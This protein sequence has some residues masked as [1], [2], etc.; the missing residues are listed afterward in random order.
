[1]NFVA[2]I[3][4]N[5]EP[6]AL[7]ID[8]T[9]TCYEN[10]SDQTSS[11]FRDVV[12]L[13]STFKTILQSLPQNG[14]DITIT[15]PSF[16]T[17]EMTREVKQA[18]KAAGFRKCHW[19]DNI[20][21]VQQGL[22]GID[23]TAR[24]ELL[25]E[26]GG[27]TVYSRLVSTDIESGIRCS[28]IIQ[29]KAAEHTGS[30]EPMI[31]QSIDDAMERL[32]VEPT[33]SAIHRILIIS[34][35][36]KFNPSFITDLKERELSAEIIIE[37]DVSQWAAKHSLS[38][39]RSILEAICIFN[40]SPLNVSI[41]KADGFVHTLIG[42]NMTLPN[43]QTAIF[44]TEKKDQRQVTVDVVVGVTPR[45]NDN[46]VIAKLVLDELASHG[47]RACMIKVTLDIEQDGRTHIIVEE[48]N[49]DG[50][51]RRRVTQDLKDVMGD[52]LDWDDVEKIIS[53]NQADFE[54]DERAD[55]AAFRW[56]GEV[57]AGALP[58]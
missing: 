5:G 4:L 24:A 14:H 34:A 38:R 21:I 45:I 18:A 43:R 37:S 46:T 1:M 20:T 3:S 6:T 25:I 28:D 32:R 9:I 42:R 51:A 52:D 11:Q 2:G 54:V 47:E 57:A 27:S 17:E 29:E 40:V 23:H 56:I 26:T 33:T 55:E 44:T 22:V 53:S 58:E 50:S 12:D 19:R 31:L 39:H 15:T 48:L 13:Q 16:Y 7:S 35:T 41:A 49:E 36:H 10:P 30:P 8:L